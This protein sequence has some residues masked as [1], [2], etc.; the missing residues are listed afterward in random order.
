[1]VILSSSSLGF[2]ESENALALRFGYPV[3]FYVLAARQAG[4]AVPKLTLAGCVLTGAIIFPVAWVIGTIAA[5]V[6]LV[7]DWSSESGV[8]ACTPSGYSR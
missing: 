8:F 4:T 1:M 5:F 3:L 2:S 7:Q 6:G